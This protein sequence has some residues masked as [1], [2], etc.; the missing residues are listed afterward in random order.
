[1]ATTDASP[2]P[3]R[4]VLEPVERTSEIVF[5]LIMA[6]SFTGS[7]EV[8]TAGREDVRPILVGAVGCNVAWGL[9]DAVMFLVTGMVARGRALTAFRALVAAVS[10]DAAR[11][12]LARLLPEG[13][14]GAMRDSELE[15]LRAEA[16]RRRDQAPRVALTLDDLRGA[17]GVFLLVFIATFPVVVPFLVVPEI[18]LAKR[19]SNGIA[20]LML[21]AAGYVFGR[22]AGGRPIWTGLASVGIGVV[23]VLLTLALGG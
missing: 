6:L 15:H 2:N 19:L 9:V 17:V 23:L 12:A 1:M 21:F 16:T 5:G 14:V 7:I 18:G 3:R 8:A 22:E 10:P 20:L 13:I 4:R 11:A